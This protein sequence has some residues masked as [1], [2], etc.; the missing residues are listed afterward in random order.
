[1]NIKSVVINANKLRNIKCKLVPK[2]NKLLNL[3]SKIN[4]KKIINKYFTSWKKD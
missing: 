1:M 3:I 4:N 2:M